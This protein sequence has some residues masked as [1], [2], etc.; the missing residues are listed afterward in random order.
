MDRWTKVGVI[1]GVIATVVV[2]LEFF[3]VQPS[4]A[5]VKGVHLETMVVAL[6]MLATWGAVYLGY[7][8]TR[9]Q[10]TDAPPVLDQASAVPDKL[11]PYSEW[12]EQYIEQVCTRKQHTGFVDLHFAKHCGCTFTNC[13]FQWDGYVAVL[14]DCYFSGY[15]PVTVDVRRFRDA[16]QFFWTNASVP[17]N[18][19]LRPSDV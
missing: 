12:A 1:A 19:V 5:V 14:D 11:I 18:A 7:R 17:K 4:G 10:V 16:V 2:V 15:A 3:G 9:R 6:M 8:N 13:T